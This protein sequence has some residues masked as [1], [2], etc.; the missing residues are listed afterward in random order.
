LGYADVLVSPRVASPRASSA[1]GRREPRRVPR[2]ALG[3]ARALGRAAGVIGGRDLLAGGAWFAVDTRRRF[4]IVTNFREFGRRGAARRRAAGSSRRTVRRPGARRVPAPAR[5]RRAGLRGLQPAARRSRL[6][7]VR[8]ESRRPVRARARRPESTA[9]RT[10]SWIRRGR[11][12]SGCGARSRALLRGSARPS[13]ATWLEGISC[14]NMLADRDPATHRTT[15]PPGGFVAPMGPA[16]L[17]APFRVST[18]TYGTRMLHRVTIDDSLR[19]AGA[20]F[21][22]ARHRRAGNQI[23]C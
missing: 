18:R 11:S 15:V 19:I 10:N 6:A 17:S 1:G 5:N 14:S 21:D 23:R 3:A 13:T 4:G 22:R 16:K 9:C 2:A 8:V 7:V 12:W 20:R